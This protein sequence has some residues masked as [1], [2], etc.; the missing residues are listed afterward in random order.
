MDYDVPLQADREI[1]SAD[2][3]RGMRWSL[4][5]DPDTFLS[6]IDPAGTRHPGR[7]R[8][9]ERTILLAFMELPASRAMPRSL[10]T[11]LRARF[12]E[13]R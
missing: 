3:L 1:E 2:W 7:T 13:A 11:A 9:Q 10:K 8:E 5:T 12:V 6:A 4:P